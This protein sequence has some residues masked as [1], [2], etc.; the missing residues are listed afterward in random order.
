MYSGYSGDC[1]SLDINLLVK[2][3]LHI[4]E[5]LKT[6]VLGSRKIILVGHSVGASIATFAV[7]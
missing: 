6:T 7:S 4:I 5:A 3:I 2:D 1:D